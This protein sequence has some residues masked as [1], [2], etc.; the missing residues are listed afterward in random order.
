MYTPRPLPRLAAALALACAGVVLAQAQY[1][2]KNKP[3]YERFDWTAYRTPRFEI[4]NYLDRDSSGA[5]LASLQWIAGLSEDWYDLHSA[6]L[7]EDLDGR[8]LMLLYANHADFQQTTAIQSAVGT[9]TGGVT[10]AFKNRVVFPFAMSNHQTDHVLGHELVHAF[11]YDL[12]LRGDSTSL[13]NLQNL[14][15]WMVEGLAEYLSIGRVDAHTAM[16]MRD[17][18][19]HGDV[20]TIKKLNN[21]KYFPYRWGQA[22]WS[23]VTGLKGDEVIRPLFE[24]TAKVGFE[25]AVRSVLGMGTENLNRLWLDALEATYRP[26]LGARDSLAAPGRRLVDEDSGGGTLNIAP[27]VS[28]DGRFVIFLSERNL[29]SIDL[30][31]ADARTGKIIRQVTSKTRSGHLDDIAYVESAGTWSPDSERFAYVGV[32]R[33]RNVLIVSDVASGKTVAE[34]TLPG[35]Q[36]FDNPAWSPDGRTIVVAGLVEGQ[37]DLYGFDVES[38]AVTQLTDSYESE[39]LP[40]FDA[41][42]ERL[43]YARDAQ[44]GAGERLNASTGFDLAVLDLATGRERV[45]DVLRGADNLN[46]GFD[47]EGHIVFLSNYDGWRDLYRYDLAGERLYR[48]T[49]VATG[50]SGITAYAPAISVS[51]RRDRI[52]YTYLEDGEYVIYSGKRADFLNEPLADPVVDLAAARLPTVNE[53]APLTVDEA[54]RTRTTALP[55]VVDRLRAG[56]GVPSE[57]EPAGFG[58]RPVGAVMADTAVGFGYAQLDNRFALDFIGGGAGI[59]VGTSIG[60]PGLGTQTGAAGGVQA[61]F[62]DVLGGQQVFA[63]ASL[64]GQIYDFAAQVAYVNRERPWGWG[65]SFSHIPYRF[66]GGYPTVTLDTLDLGNGQGLEAL[67]YDL[68]ED[69]LFEDRLGVF[70][71]RPF[72]RALRVEGGA[73]YARYSRRVDRNQLYYDAFGRLIA[74]ERDRITEGVPDGFGVGSVSAA[75]VGDNSVMGPTSPLSGWRFRAGVEQFFGADAVR[76]LNYTQST[77]DGRIYQRLAPVTLALRAVHYGRHGLDGGNELTFPFYVGQQWYVRGL[78]DQGLVQT[79]GIANDFDFDALVGNNLALVNAE[80]RLPFTGPRRLGLINFPWLYTE[81]TAFVDGGL[82]YDSF[83]EVRE[84][85][86]RRDAFTS[87]GLP[88]F[89]GD[90][91]FSLGRPIVTGG[92]SLRAN[93][94]G[95]IIVEPYYARVLNMEGAAWDFGVNIVPGW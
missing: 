51:P 27:Q 53:R 31:L 80:I 75:L 18:V 82:A 29:L 13:R 35:V 60:N 86:D 83:A 76:D 7:D 8:N 78:G 26:F 87:E 23:F 38:E 10:E 44:L 21:P 28:P 56:A 94:L 40:S 63:G 65:A 16:W 45:L 89:E 71:D 3:R 41:R 73:S 50:I 6:A 34:Y 48:M 1:F 36:A 68:L 58:N 57:Y 15:L 52:A 5:A 72:S 70:V 93:V 4:L 22:W 88:D 9:G 64:N 46:P 81:L 25:P 79:L 55:A 77:L 24:Q 54:L 30:F 47:H 17:A 92:V 69:R 95:A 2:G 43:V 11:Q 62:S 39:L 74:Q 32:S 61:L 67:R 84:F 90:D 42:G 66:F 49:E 20:P 14:P 85:Y 91:F 12:V 33:G 59:G 37:V 19:L